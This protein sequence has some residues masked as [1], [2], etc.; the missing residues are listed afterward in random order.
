MTAE[1]LDAKF[2]ALSANVLSDDRQREVKQAIFSAQTMS[3]RDFMKQ[4][5]T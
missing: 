4:L 3:C 2:G 5:V 1:D